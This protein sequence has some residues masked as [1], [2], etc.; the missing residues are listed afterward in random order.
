MGIAPVPCASWS[1]YKS[2]IVTDLFP[3][4][5]FRRGKYLFRGQ[6]SNAW[7]LSSTFDRWYKGPREKRFKTAERLL[8]EFIRECEGEDL[9]DSIRNDRDGML[10]LAQHNGLPTRL[11]DWSESPYVAAFFAFSGHIRSGDPADGQ[12]AIWTLDTGSFVWHRENGC[13]IL[14][15]P[16]FGNER[17]RNQHGRFT[18]L[19]APYDSLEEYAGSFSEQSALR[20]YVVPGR[21]AESAM[22]DLDTMGLSHSRI[23]PGIGG[24]AKAAEVR[25]LLN[26][27][28]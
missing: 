26:P 10:G 17:I 5:R 18:Y 24:N 8:D 1:D 12:V 4:G 23:Y 16:S 11:L 3:D 15:V 6:G 2:R 28:P 9:P 19:R 21:D 25:V 13:E 7:A 14:S 22:A 27:V 20:K